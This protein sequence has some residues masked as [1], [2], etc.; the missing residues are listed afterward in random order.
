LVKAELLDAS[1]ATLDQ[2]DQHDDEQHAGSNPDKS[3]TVHF[4][5]LSK[6]E[7]VEYVPGPDSFPG[8]VDAEAL[9]P[10]S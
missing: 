8:A 5:F 6:H 10:L 4:K 2:D 9:L 7:Q 1:A 3:G